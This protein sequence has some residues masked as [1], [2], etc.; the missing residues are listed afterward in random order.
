MA[1]KMVGKS[2]AQRVG[3][4]VCMKVDLKVCKWVGLLAE[5]KADTRVA[6]M[7]IPMV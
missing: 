7:D 5:V 4:M 3:R 1:D 2:V 6:S